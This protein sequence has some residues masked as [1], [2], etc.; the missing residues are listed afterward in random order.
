MTIRGF[1]HRLI[2]TSAILVVV[3]GGVMLAA[4]ILRGTLGSQALAKQLGTVLTQ[5][6]LDPA[7]TRLRFEDVTGNPLTGLTLTHVRLEVRR[8]DGHGWVPVFAAKRI[9]V[10]YEP[11]ELVR[12]HFHFTSL[13]L[14]D[15]VFR[16]PGPGVRAPRT[17]ARG[18]PAPGP[19]APLALAVD[20][21]AITGGHVLADSAT[22]PRVGNLSVA[23]LG[24]DLHGRISVA[25]RTTQGQIDSL[26]I[27]PAGMP[28][29]VLHGQIGL[30][31]SQL[32]IGELT[33]KSR[34]TAIWVEGAL[35]TKARRGHLTA[36]L[37]PL[38]LAD[39][40]AFLGAEWLNR[41]GCVRGKVS[42][43]GALGDLGFQADLV[44]VAGADTVQRF[45]IAGRLQP[46]ALTIGDLDLTFDEVN[47][48]GAGWV[49]FGK[50]SPGTHGLVTFEDVDLRNLPGLRH[51][52]G[53]PPGRLS[54]RLSVSAERRSPSGPVRPFELTVSE[55]EVAGL[56][57]VDGRVLGA[58]GRL[59]ALELSEFTFT[60]RG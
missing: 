21:L 54:G 35:D 10:T 47:Y 14:E 56:E 1:L 12:G 15:P 5:S 50:L 33:V 7:T 16:L 32:E 39:A 49:G 34:A 36:E 23:G 25:G 24:F 13:A 8:E 59:D 17:R 26:I 20:Q 19:R 46:E 31:G 22:A 44:A 48:H 28:P 52:A 43:D 58:L 53:L 45:A 2:L 4:A 29:L 9:W 6:V 3:I 55:G 60:T 11:G 41:P 57:I 51:R 27:H 18:A 30:D 40:R 42:A 38:D 37:D